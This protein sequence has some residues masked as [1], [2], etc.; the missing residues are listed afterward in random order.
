MS[1]L[2]KTRISEFDWLKVLGLFLLIFVHSDLTSTYPA[3]INTFQTILISIFFFV[4][5]YLAYKSFHKRDASIKRFF[6]SKF[7]TLYLPFVAAAC[8]YFALEA[9]LAGSSPLKLLAQISLLDVFDNINTGLFNY[10]F[11][12]FIPYLLVFFMFFC[13]LEKYVKN[14]KIQVSIALVLWVLNLVAWVFDDP[15]KFTLFSLKL[16]L[17]FNQFFLVFMLGFWVSKY[18][19]SGRLVQFKT[20]AFAILLL[21]L[22]W[23]DFSGSLSFISPLTGFEHYFYSNLRSM[24]LGLSVIFILLALMKGRVSGNRIVES[25][26]KVSI[27]IYLIEPFVSFLLREYIFGG[28]LHIYLNDTDHFIL[29]QTARIAF[30]FGLLPLLYLVAK[31][32]GIFAK[33]SSRLSFKKT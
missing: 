30:L 13:L 3:I 1:Q 12:W 22:F 17:V 21:V 2:G 20:A 7:W 33:I 26:A 19:L 25:I 10:G 24:A 9:Y 11:L 32:Y 27:L 23:F 6:K 4:S 14:T 5:G 31:K 18:N 29:Y 15:S 28:Q 16:G 8:L